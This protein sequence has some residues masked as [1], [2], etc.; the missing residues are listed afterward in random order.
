M[1][2]PPKGPLLPARD[3]MT[4]RP[5]LQKM[6]SLWEGHFPSLASVFSFVT[7]GCKLTSK[8]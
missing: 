2:Y 3:L 7:W 8:G 4:V 1:A 5:S 6:L